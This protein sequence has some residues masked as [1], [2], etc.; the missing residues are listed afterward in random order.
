MEPII[1]LLEAV[2]S[3]ADLGRLIRSRTNF[4]MPL[5][6]FFDFFAV[7]E[8]WSAMDMSA[9]GRKDTR[10]SQGICHFVQLPCGHGAA[11]GLPMK[12][13]GTTSPIL[14]VTRLSQVHNIGKFIQSQNLKEIS[15]LLVEI[16]H[17]WRFSNSH[18]YLNPFMRHASRIHTPH[19]IIL[20]SLKSRGTY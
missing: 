19:K 10:Q 13:S 4:L 3:L 12:D 5:D 16:S 14:T 17:P 1:Y 18:M 2:E 8:I 7:G 15:I 11:S 6:F 9:R 20:Y